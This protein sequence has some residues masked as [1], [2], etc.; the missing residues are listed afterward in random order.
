MIYYFFSIFRGEKFLDLV[1]RLQ[2]V[3]YELTDRLA[4]YLC[5]KKP[6]QYRVN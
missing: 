4:F 2:E 3:Q 6:G 1:D 5:G